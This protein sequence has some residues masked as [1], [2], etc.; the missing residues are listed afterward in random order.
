MS[1][2]P[3]SSSVFIPPSRS[4]TPRP[5]DEGYLNGEYDHLSDLPLHH[6]RS[7]QMGGVQ[8]LDSSTSRRRVGAST[9][10]S[11]TPEMLSASTGTHEESSSAALPEEEGFDESK[12]R[13]GDAAKWAKLIP[14]SVAGPKRRTLAHGR[15]RREGLLGWVSSPSLVLLALDQHDSQYDLAMDNSDLLPLFAYTVL[16]LFT[17]LY[18]IGKSNTVVWDEVRSLSS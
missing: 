9:N 7:P 13:R 2:P 17:R 4:P 12:R 6:T 14:E 5:G 8:I 11:L 15:R 3:S 18:D 10:S 16:S 1:L